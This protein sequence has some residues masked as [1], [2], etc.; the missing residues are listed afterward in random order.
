[1]LR[2]LRIQ[3]FAL[4]RELAV[5]FGP[6]LN[7]LTGE[8]G[9][10]KSIIV[11]A[12]G[13]LVGER[14]S[15]EQIRSGSEA[16]VV[17]GIF[18]YEDDHNLAR[19]L[20][21]SGIPREE[22][23]I[24]R[25]EVAST[26]RGRVYV[27]NTLCTL[28]LLKSLGEA[29]ADI[30]GQQDQRSL[31]E[32]ASHREWLD[33][34]GRNQKAVGEVRKRHAALRETARQLQSLQADAQERARRIDILQF[35]VDEIRRA[36]LA[37]GEKEDLEQERRMLLN[38][39][40]LFTLASE[41]YATLYDSENS[42]AGQVKRLERLLGDLEGIDPRWSPHREVLAE[43]AYKMEDLAFALRDYTSGMDFS[44]ERLER[45]EG[46]LA[47]IERLA[48]KYGPGVEEVLAFCRKSELELAELSGCAETSESLRR[49][50]DLE[51]DSYL[52]AARSLSEKRQRD[53][54]RLRRELLQEFQA[55]ALEK[56][57][58]D[59]HFH[60]QGA[61]PAGEGLPAGYGP[62]GIDEVEFQVS[63]NV[64][65]D[66]KPL[67]RIASGGEL[68][69]IMLA[70]QSRCGADDGNRTLVFDEVDAGIGG[71]VAAAVG[72]RLHDLAA[73]SQVL[74]VTHLPQIA[75]FA[76]RHYCVAKQVVGS[77]TETFVQLLGRRD[78]RVEEIAR[79]MG[80]LSITE[81][82]RRH[83]RE[84]LSSSAGERGPRGD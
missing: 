51:L 50:R 44:P 52:E 74:C 56:M 73:H 58:L 15:S 64:G 65:E 17:E 31:L 49:R 45:V 76:D 77:R 13:L 30:H 81:A 11:D 78:E 41:A 19:L 33:R 29:L 28:A 75:A 57:R 71:R 34:F 84:L 43:T 80:G 25:R 21:D 61:A 63:P 22:N 70:V 55:L 59:I 68:S 20:E 79:M 1:M 7:L 12:L 2:M 5:E 54:A 37:P 36:R 18:S 72:R 83:A 42:T 46:R 3:N 67:A 6:G 66:L 53:A 62:T 14:S 48:G 23:V 8:T 9:S 26:A 32:L 24:V 10:G 4:I 47:E 40:R 16:A 27:N 69:R 39:E 82:A 60:P 38:R 35:Q